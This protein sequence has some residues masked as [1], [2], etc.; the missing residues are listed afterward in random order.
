MRRAG[1]LQPHVL[2]ELARKGRRHLRYDG[3]AVAVVL[4]RHVH[5]DLRTEI[6]DV[7]DPAAKRPIAD[8]YSLRAEAHRDVPVRLGYGTSGGAIEH[9][10]GSADLKG[11]S[12]AK[13]DKVHRG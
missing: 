2:V 6:L 3:Q 4:H 7:P 8:A 13:R 11:S 5:E 10:L 1:D 12:A 9:Q